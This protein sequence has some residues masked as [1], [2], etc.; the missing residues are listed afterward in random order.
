MGTVRVSIKFKSRNSKNGIS[1]IIAFKLLVVL[2]IIMIGLYVFSRSKWTH[3]FYPEVI[4]THQKRKCNVLPNHS[5]R[6]SLEYGH[7]GIIS[8]LEQS[9]YI[10]KR[11]FTIKIRGWNVYGNINLKGTGIFVW[12]FDNLDRF[13]HHFHVR[14]CLPV[15]GYQFG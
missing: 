15:K 7:K 11:V 9:Q 8:T 14:R 4:L 6:K 10:H 3:T 12:R 13:Y 1:I 2:A 5:S